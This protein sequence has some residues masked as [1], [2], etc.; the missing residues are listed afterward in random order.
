MKKEKAVGVKHST[1]VAWLK[2][3][4]EI[5]SQSEMADK[6]FLDD[7]RELMRQR[8]A[9][10]NLTQTSLAEKVGVKQ[11]L[12]SQF[13]AGTKRLGIEVLVATCRELNIIIFASRV[14]G[15][16]TTAKV[17]KKRG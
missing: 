9:E 7:V 5:M 4:T 15:K 12:Y 1:V 17:D 11:S 16:N 14:E 8:M 2:A 3:E 6:L 10:L 13:F